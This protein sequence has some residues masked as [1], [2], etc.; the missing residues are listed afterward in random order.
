MQRRSR[1]VSLG[2]CVAVSAALLPELI[3]RTSGQTT[4]ADAAQRGIGAQVTAAGQGSRSG[5][6]PV[7]VTHGALDDVVPRRDV[8]A[9]AAELKAL[10]ALPG[11]LAHRQRCAPPSDGQNSQPTDWAGWI[12]GYVA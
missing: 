2:S 1:G 8:D 4:S 12:G 7:L 6:T 3:G 10:G 11:S 9:S 5:G